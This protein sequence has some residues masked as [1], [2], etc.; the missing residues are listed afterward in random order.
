MAAHDPTRFDDYFNRKVIWYDD[1]ARAWI[2]RA[3]DGVIVQIG[4]D[5][6][7]TRAFVADNDDRDW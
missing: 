5:E 7:D 1:D 4:N 6:S 2:G 3:A